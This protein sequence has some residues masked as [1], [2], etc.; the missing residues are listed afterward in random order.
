[1]RVMGPFE[2]HQPLARGGHATVHVARWAGTAGDPPT[3]E[4]VAKV[5][6]DGAELALHT[7]NATLRA[8]EHPN[9][10]APVGF[11]DDATQAALVLPRAACSLRAHAAT[12]RRARS[13]AR[14]A[15]RRRRAGRAA[16][17]RVRA[18]RHHGGQRVV[19]RRRHPGA[20]ATSAAP[21]R[22]R[23]PARTRTSPRSARVLRESLVDG[24][25][26]QL[27]TLL[28]DVERAPCDAVAFDAAAA[29]TRDRA[30]PVR[31]RLGRARGHGAADHRGRL[32]P[33][34]Y[35]SGRSKRSKSSSASRSTT[36]RA[37]PSRTN[38]TAGRC[39]FW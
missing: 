12:P 27:G 34:G 4:L 36:L 32:T 38:T 33:G 39:T 29:G 15:R 17:R 37:S 10:I 21:C 26:S 31:P 35:R 3:S 2:I 9:V 19:A 30:A 1:M 24:G 18:R 25:S 28:G 11:V 14:R 13:D 6:F 7:E 23:T 22:A 20:R 16:P 8:V 5:A